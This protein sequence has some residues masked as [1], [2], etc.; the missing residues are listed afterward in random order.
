MVAAG[1]TA[2]DVTAWIAEVGSPTSYS[3]SLHF[4]EN[5]FT[6]SQETPNMPMQVDES[7]RYALD[8]TT[9]VLTIGDAGN[10]D[11]YTFETTLT[12]DAL[13]LALVDSTEQG[14]EDDKAH[15]RRYTIAF[16]CSAP[17]RRQ[18]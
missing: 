8:G 6:H 17:F 11:T 18:P 2:D 16:Y 9:L 15:H 14:T 1:I 13:S 10:I 4:T 12:G 7:G 3:F 5:A